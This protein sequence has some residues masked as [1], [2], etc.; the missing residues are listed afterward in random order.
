MN[1]FIAIGSIVLCIYFFLKI[2]Y[3]PVV[4]SLDKRIRII[5]AGGISLLFTYFARQFLSVQEL[6]V[7]MLFFLSLLWD[8]IGFIVHK[9][10]KD[11]LKKWHKRIDLKGLFPVVMVILIVIYGYI[12]IHD[13]IWANYE[14]TTSKKIDPLRIALIGDVHLSTTM[15]EDTFS[16]YMKEIEAKQVDIVLLVGDIFDETTTQEDMEQASKA[17]GDIKS[18]YGTYYV[19]GNHDT[20]DNDAYSQNDMVNTLIQ[21][22]ITILDDKVK[23]I[24]NQFYLIGRIDNWGHRNRNRTREELST[25]LAG[26]DKDKFIILLDH[27]PNDLKKNAKL[28]IDLQLAGHT[29]GGQIWPLGPLTEM[30]GN[31][32]MNYG[33]RQDGDYQIIVTSGMGGW[34]YPLR[35]ISKSEMVI[36]DVEGK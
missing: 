26:L 17:L 2:M 30:I 18:T 23:L 29:H 31:T 24:N 15:N 12:N 6:L 3:L 10:G 34:G 11:T 36:I 14:V 25:L 16:E 28:G 5:L 1:G 13:V 32:E 7:F 8:I 22:N 21:S 4:S 9:K 35:I 33:L 20:Y 27:T 19:Y